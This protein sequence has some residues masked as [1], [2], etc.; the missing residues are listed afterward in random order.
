VPTPATSTTLGRSGCVM[1]DFYVR[2]RGTDADNAE[3][4]PVGQGVPDRP[5]GRLQC[6]E[7]DCGRGDEGPRSGTRSRRTGRLCEGAIHGDGSKAE[8]RRSEK[9][10]LPETE[11]EAAGETRLA[12]IVQV[13]PLAG[14][15]CRL[16]ASILR[17]ALEEFDDAGLTTGGGST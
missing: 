9:Y 4:P 10:G 16:L 14:E 2:M 12:T 13:Q 8:K 11:R 1:T 7:A 17:R 6:S 15:L 5:C 3:Q